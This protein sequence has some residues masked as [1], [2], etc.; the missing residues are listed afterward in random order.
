MR[1]TT[2][3]LWREETNSAPWIIRGPLRA[4]SSIYG[5]C[6]RVRELAYKRGVFST[7]EVSIPVIS[8]GNITLGGTGK[9]PIV[10]RLSLG[11]KEI[12][13]NPGIITRGYK[14][15]RKGIFSVDVSRDDADEVGD[16]AFMLARKT[17]VPVIVGTKRAKAIDEGVRTFNIDLALL[18]DGFQVRNL[19]KDM[20]ILLL[21]G[22]SNSHPNYRLFPSGPCREPLDRIHEADVI[23]INKGELDRTVKSFAAG[24]PAFRMKYKPAYLYN[25]KRDMIAHYNFLKGKRIVAFSGLG[26]NQSF[27]SLLREIGGRIIETVEFP[28]HYRYRDEDIQY[29]ASFKGAELLITTEKDAVK[30]DRMEIPD[31]LFY[32]AIEAKIERERDL[33]ELIQRKVSSIHFQAVNPA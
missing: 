25:V 24:I 14:R 27:F 16:E 19:R 4:L 8:V 2:G 30:I 12:G 28:D 29:L 21:N 10:E 6:L 17:R 9:T 33:L 20:E 3:K 7:D 11:L 18:D 32:L 31:N 13:F 22:T 5:F 1:K 15:K 23:L 26:D